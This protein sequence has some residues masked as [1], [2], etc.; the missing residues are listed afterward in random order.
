MSGILL[1]QDLAVVLVIAGAAAWMCR[2]LGLSAVVGYLAAGAIIGPHTPPFALVSDI[3][4]V[5]TLAELGLVFLIF[6]IGMNL[7]LNRL[8]RL[9]LPVLLATL[10]GALIVLSGGRLFGWALGWDATAGLFLAAMLMVSS[11]AIISKVLDEQNL[12]HERPGQLA[13]G[14]TVLEDI[15]AIVMLT[16]LTSLVQFGAA[17]PPPL[18]PTLGALGAF[19]VFVAL[20]S[21]L[22]MPKLLANVSRDALPEIR[23]LLV[24]GLLLALAWLAVKL[25]YS[26]AL[27]AFVFGAIIGSTRH[28]T[29]IM[30]SFEGLDQTFG[31]VF[32]VAV[33]MM[34]DFRMLPAALPLMLGLTAAALVLRP[35]ACALGLLLVGNRS[36]DSIRAALSLSPL[37]EFSFIIA[38]LGVGGGVLPQTAYPVAV[39]ASL[40]TSLASPLLT[41][42]AEKISGSIERAQPVFVRQLLDLYQGLLKRLRDRRTAS[43]LWR[44]TGK[45][46]LQLAVYI[47]MVSAVLLLAEPLARALRERLIAEGHLPQGFGLLFLAVVGLLLA[48][49]LIAVWRNAAALAMIV[50]ESAT[51]GAPRQARLRPTLETLLRGVAA[52]LLGGWLLNML[53]ADRPPGSGL[54]LG[55]L[56]VLLALFFWRRFVWLHSRLEFELATSLH[57]ATRA[58]A[59]PGWSAELARQSADWNLDLDEIVIPSDAAHIGRT[60]GQLALRSRCGCSVVGIDR[61]GHVIANPSAEM[62]IY[63]L[64]RL[65]LLGTGGQLAC[66]ARELGGAGRPEA[67]AMDFDELIMDSLVVPDA[68]PLAGK[69]LIELD[70]IRQVGVQIGGIRHGTQERLTPAGGDSFTAGD[71]LLVI[72]SPAQIARFGRLLAAPQSSAA[73]G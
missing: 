36:G 50:A 69:T 73:D 42:H 65:L 5:Q 28:K 44:H 29:E 45:R 27:G 51:A 8:Q 33:G 7:G 56:I 3:A 48:G 10:F 61:H 52:I 20:M 46:L 64:D 9:G 23:T 58:A 1:I 18:L 37:G 49:P 54:V 19:V 4:R 60:I 13:L 24:A 59:T 43:V 62:V 38:Q 63:P 41:R 11:S 68:S 15:V 21:L 66:A 22:V 26:L 67:S 25:G 16:V 47:T 17:S 30:R 55:L 71:E 14:V 6:S 72:G 39:G 34:V 53:P 32:F 70:L 57:D 35:V 31:A 40:L 2:R 12:T